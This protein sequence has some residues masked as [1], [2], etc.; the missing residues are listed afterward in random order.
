MNNDENTW[1]SVYD[2]L[3]ELKSIFVW[4][5]QAVPFLEE[6]M[7]F[8][9]SLIP[10]ID[11][12]NLS[13]SESTKRFPSAE[14]QLNDVTKATELATNEILRLLEIS[15]KDC[16]QISK[17]HK[18]TGEIIESFSASKAAL[19]S[20]I[21]TALS[22]ADPRIHVLHAKL[23]QQTEKLESQ[24]KATNESDK[25]LLKTVKSNLNKIFM[26]LQVQDITTQQIS[27]VNNVI[28][29]I[30]SQLSNLHD[31][32]NNIKKID[33]P[34]FSLADAK[35][36]E[37]DTS[38]SPLR[39]IAETATAEEQV[40]D[41]IIPLES[42]QTFDANASYDRNRQRKKQKEADKMIEMISSGQMEFSENEQPQDA[43]VAADDNGPATAEP[44]SAADMD[45]DALFGGGASSESSTSNDSGE[46]AAST[47]DIDKLFD[48]NGSSASNDDI[49]KLFGG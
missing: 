33:A 5:D 22:G 4:G 26:S 35:D 25:Q 41:E 27:A 49:D 45:I 39:A 14:S 46:E 24:L 9:E 43:P 19:R 48:S 10:L 42:G 29:S 31:R 3:S 28:Q 17:S 44:E 32:L 40:T 15:L 23:W 1:H 8:I 11:E 20:E 21:R 38:E 13:I 16:G 18:S 34:V 2:T 7:Q 37:S 30:Q 6:M 47:D 36:T 12:I